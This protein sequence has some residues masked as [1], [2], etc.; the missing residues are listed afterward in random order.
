MK[1][2]KPIRIFSPHIQQSQSL[3]LRDQNRNSHPGEKKLSREVKNRKHR[4][5]HLQDQQEVAQGR[6]TKVS[7]DDSIRK[8]S[9]HSGSYGKNWIT[10]LFVQNRNCGLVSLSVRPQKTNGLSYTAEVPRVQRAQGKN[11]ERR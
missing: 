7:Q 2:I 10:K 4:Q 6:L 9:D 3:H 8:L 5:N 1:K 11:V